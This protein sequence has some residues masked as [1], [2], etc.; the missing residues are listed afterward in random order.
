MIRN[1]PDDFP[2][3]VRNLAYMVAY[4]THIRVTC[5]ECKEWQD[6]DTL[7]LLRRIKRPEYSLIDRRCR[8]RLTPGC[9]G[10]N[11]FNY[12]L[13]VYRKLWTDDAASRWSD[14]D[15]AERVAKWKADAK[16]LDG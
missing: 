14:E 9:V 7:A 1:H 3:W 10:W 16:P 4:Q 2:I 8:C 6:V 12:L 11:R 13:G 15:Y 5:T